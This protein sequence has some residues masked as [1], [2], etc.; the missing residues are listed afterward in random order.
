MKKQKEEKMTTKI[1]I[2]WFIVLSFP[3]LFA[4]LVAGIKEENK[5]LKENI[6]KITYAHV[7]Y[8]NGTDDY[9]VVKDLIENSNL[10]CQ[11]IYHDINKESS[12]YH[13]VATYFKLGNIVYNPLVAINN[14]VFTEANDEKIIEEINNSIE[15]YNQEN[16]S[17]DDIAVY[18]IVDR[19]SAKQ[20]IKNEK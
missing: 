17:S 18:N 13:E 16:I 2:I 19:I 11:I 1:I 15:T 8:L 4:L 3:V 7:F 20:E 12:L 5:S 6:T 10:D 9:K 14:K